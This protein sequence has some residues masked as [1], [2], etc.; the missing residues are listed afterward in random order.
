MAEA[1]SA[2]S[3]SRPAWAFSLEHMRQVS[4]MTLEDPHTNRCL[5][6]C[7]QPDDADDQTGLL[8]PSR[9]VVWHGNFA[10]L[11]D[12]ARC[13]RWPS[14]IRVT[15]RSIRSSKDVR[16][17]VVYNYHRYS[18]NFDVLFRCGQFFGYFQF[19]VW[20]EVYHGYR[21]VLEAEIS[22]DVC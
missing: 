3:S 2:W 7:R 5:A 11:C 8:L 10:S 6:I 17:R 15:G 18:G 22:V 12:I 9:N 13:N 16:N 19:T 21:W 20:L 1:F 14:H 4:Q